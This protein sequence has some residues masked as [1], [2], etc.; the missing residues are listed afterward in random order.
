MRC[1]ITYVYDHAICVRGADMRALHG[2]V[3]VFMM[4]V[5]GVVGYE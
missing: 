5:C 4:Y 1:V 2:C 3:Y